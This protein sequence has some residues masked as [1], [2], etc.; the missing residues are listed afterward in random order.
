MFL[1]KNKGNGAYQKSQKS[2]MLNNT[3][4][5]CLPTAQTDKGNGFKGKRKG[6]TGKG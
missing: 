4:I 5:A 6:E 2:D 3:H 1:L